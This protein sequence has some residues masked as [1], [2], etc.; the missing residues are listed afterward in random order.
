MTSKGLW[1]RS[2]TKPLHGVIIIVNGVFNNITEDIM[3]YVIEGTV[4]ELEVKKE[5]EEGK[6]KV[7]WSFKITGT[8]GYALRQK[9][10]KDNK[11]TR[12]NVLCLENTQVDE[13]KKPRNAITFAED[14]PFQTEDKEYGCLITSALADGRKCKFCFSVKEEDKKDFD[15]KNCTISSLALLAE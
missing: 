2:F 11:E 10:K 15:S 5:K 9:K 4:K 1:K 13:D 12:L 14:S 3:E 7:I 6:G 8:D